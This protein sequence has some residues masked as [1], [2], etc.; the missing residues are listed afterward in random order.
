MGCY[1]TNLQAAMVLIYGLVDKKGEGP[2]RF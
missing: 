1:L 2:K